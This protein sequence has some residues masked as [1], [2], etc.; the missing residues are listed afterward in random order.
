M[1]GRA[2][3]RPAPIAVDNILSNA[4]NAAAKKTVARRAALC[5][6]AALREP[7]NHSVQR[8]VL[9]RA[10][11]VQASREGSGLRWRTGGRKRR[12]QP[13]LRGLGEGR[14]KVKAKQ[15]RWVSEAARFISHVLPT[16]LRPGRDP[17]CSATAPADMTG[18]GARHITIVST[19]TPT[20]LSAMARVA[21]TSMEL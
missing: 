13:W 12:M 17:P 14:L 11:E 8:H 15:Q 18:R 7:V 20:S 2:P 6:T 19:M 1:L 4:S 5:D 3:P 21:A 10:L 9:R 16:Q